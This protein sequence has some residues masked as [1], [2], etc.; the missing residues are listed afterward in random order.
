MIGH[1][2]NVSPTYG[3]GWVSADGA[4]RET[5]EPFR[6]GCDGPDGTEGIII[7]DHEFAGATVHLSP[8][9]T[10]PDGHFNVEIRR[11]ALTLAQGYAEA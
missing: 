11:D 1:L 2:R 8:R 5:P 3:W 10:T 6:F 9:H 7:G 4:T